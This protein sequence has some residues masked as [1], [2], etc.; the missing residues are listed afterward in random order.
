MCAAGSDPGTPPWLTVVV[1]NWNGRPL[2]AD[3]LGSLERA[4]AGV[5]IVLV[6]NAS[7]DDSVAWTRE[8][9]P[10]VEIL[11]SGEN[12]RWAGGN[13]LALRR[14]RDEGG[15]EPVL[16]LNNDTIVPE[17]SLERLVA[18]LDE[19][20]DAWA[21]TPRIC[22]AEEPG[23]L[24]YDGARVGAWS[25]WVRHLG[26]RR[27]AGERPRRRAD[28]DYGTGCALLVSR[29]ALHEVGLLDERYWLYA[30]DTDYSLRVRAA[31]GR[32][33]HE[34]SALVLHK[35]SRTTG[36]DTPRKAYLKSRSHVTLLR[37]HW[38][39]RTWPLLIPS[40]LAYVAAQGGWHLFHGRPDTARAAVLGALDALS[41]RGAPDGSR[42]DGSRG[43]ATS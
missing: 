29:R 33:V 39:R 1:V 40:Q 15:P 18:A 25:G 36:A 10:R 19:E 35:V 28:T 41:G 20:P 2:L 31:G 4:G 13:N 5:R 30:E 17:G 11:R 34:P 24:W 21:A 16:L 27:P 12:L 6:D 8:H 43:P 22:Y 26:L 9:H 38:R 42:I 7:A 3:C 32:I 37:A 14:L 23:T